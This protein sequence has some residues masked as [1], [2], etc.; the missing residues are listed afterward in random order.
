MIISI[1]GM[2]G[3]GK[4]TLSSKLHNH[5]QNSIIVEEFQKDDLI[6]NTFLDWCYQQKPNIDISFQ[7]YIV[8]ALSQNFYDHLKIY[9]NLDKNS[10]RYMF[11]D[12]FTLEHYVFAK[13]TLLK[14]EPKYFEAFEALFENILDVKTNPDFAIYLDVDFLTAKQRIFKRQRASEVDNW[15]ANE[16]YFKQLSDMYK[17]EFIKLALKYS[18]PFAIIDA[19]SLNEEQILELAINKIALYKQKQIN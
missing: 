3:S 18:I 14:K 4:S 7:A 13:V 11:L 16:A 9:K 1:S 10:N 8:E 6:F 19:N 15:D 17:Q 5:F 12:R 2:I